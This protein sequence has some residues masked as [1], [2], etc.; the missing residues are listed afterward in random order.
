MSTIKCYVAKK[1]KATLE[2]FQY[3][4]SA[5]GPLDILV[6]ITHCGVCLTDLQLINDDRKQSIYPLVPGHEIVGMITQ[7]GSN[8]A[9]F[10][11][12]DRVGIGFQR[13]SCG[14]C[15]WCRQGDENLCLKEE[16]TCNGHYGGYAAAIVADSR[17][18]F[19]IPKE[20]SSENAAPLLC[21]G[22][23]VFAPLFHQKIDPTC[24]VGVI[25]IGGLGHLALKFAH[26]FGCEVIAFSS[27][28]H[29]EREAKEFGAHHFISSVDSKSIEKAADSI[30]L[31]ICS[32]PKEMDWEAYITTLRPKGTLCVVGIPKGG[33]IEV[34]IP[35]LTKRR[36]SISGS[37]IASPSDIRKMLN[38]AAFH[39]IAPK[40]E[41][42]P[43]S[44]VNNVLKKLAAN[45]IHYRAV[46]KN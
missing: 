42:F 7:K 28:P 44:E 18:A 35:G 38:F 36:K 31:I 9:D 4:P 19:L 2:P 17:F 22:A 41:V 21:G 8:V 24:R 12:G 23:T 13:G 34:A 25:G 43:M 15:E 14:R 33:R 16:V 20:L 5:L 29:K 32:A 27:S 10:E 39:N 11:I 26:A 1:A 37:H 40:T 46:L 6:E 3:E 30:D 45:Q